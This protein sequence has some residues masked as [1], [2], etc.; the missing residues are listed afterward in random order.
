MREVG[1]T[2]D[3]STALAIG[4]EMGSY[5]SQLGFNVDFAPVADVLT[6]PENTVVRDRS[7][8]SDPDLVAVYANA[9]VDGLH[10]YGVAATMKHFPGH[11]STT[12]D[13]HAGYACSWQT[14][15]EL[16]SCDL[17]PFQA[18]IDHNVDLIMAGHISL[19]NV[20]GDMLPASLSG[21]VITTLL[22]EKMHYDGV[23]ITD[24]LNMGAITD[25]YNSA[26]A[27]VLA[28]QAGCD[29]LLMPADWRAARDG[30]R[31]AVEEGVITEER[32]DESVRRIIE[33]KNAF[34]A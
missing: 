20:T 10:E 24:A 33:L 13:S 7:F 18:G 34:F 22:R 8:G 16:F 15:D 3:F 27:A 26:E 32:I 11:G 12:E 2:M 9:I 29:L 30:L 5:L 25:H 28:I 31:K 1:A 23:V 17:I 21:T 4:M 6:N 19:P 14:E